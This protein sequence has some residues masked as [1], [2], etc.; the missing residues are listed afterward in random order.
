MAWAEFA[1]VACIQNVSITE[2]SVEHVIHVL[3]RKCELELKILSRNF[4]AN[5]IDQIFVSVMQLIIFE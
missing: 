1:L 4:I 5:L 2:G 3:R